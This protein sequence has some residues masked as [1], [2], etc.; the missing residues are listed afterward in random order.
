[1]VWGY[2]IGYKQ[3]NQDLTLNLSHIKYLVK[4]EV[5]NLVWRYLRTKDG[6]QVQNNEIVDKT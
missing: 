5:L 4:Y 1:M 6:T 2:D 3:R